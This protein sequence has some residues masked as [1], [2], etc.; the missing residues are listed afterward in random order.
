M[1]EFPREQSCMSEV[2]RRA[3]HRRTLEILM[4][5]DPGAIDE[6]AIDIQ[7]ENVAK[8]RFRSR[9]FAATDDIAR[10]LA[11]V[12]VPLKSIWGAR[13]ILAHPSFEAVREVLARHHPELDMR[14][15]AD[16][17]HWVMYEQGDAFNAELVSVLG[18]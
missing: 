1:E 13:D 14:L 16:A 15:V 12:V 9:P 5:A 4:F 17:G 7:A 8:T 11:D 2:E 3:V 10:A 18:L 6:S